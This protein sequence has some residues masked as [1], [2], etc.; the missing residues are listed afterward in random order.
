M[1]RLLPEE[2]LFERGWVEV[3]HPQ[4]SPDVASFVS[5]TL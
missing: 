5:R 3:H 2:A 4:T 1:G